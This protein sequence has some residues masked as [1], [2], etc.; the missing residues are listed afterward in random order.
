MVIV[1]PV[2]DKYF[3]AFKVSNWSED[4]DEFVVEVKENWCKKNATIH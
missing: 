1:E 4:L 2:A 3:G